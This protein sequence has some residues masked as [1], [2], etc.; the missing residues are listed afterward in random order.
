MA[1]KGKKK[2]SEYQKQK[3]RVKA[4]KKSMEKRGYIFPD[5]SFVERLT[6]AFEKSTSTATRFLKGL[7][8]GKMQEKSI[9]VDVMTGEV[10]SGVA[11]RRKE[12]QKAYKKG[13][14]PTPPTPPGPEPTP[15]TPPGPEP[16]PP[17]PPGP[18]PEP[19][20]PIE[21]EFTDEALRVLENMIVEW[22][23]LGSW[24]D[25]F[26]ILKEQDRNTAYNILMG[27]IDDLGREQVARN[28]QNNAVTL[29]WILDHILYDSGE[30]NVGPGREGQ[31]ANLAHFTTLVRS[32]A[33]TLQQARAIDEAMESDDG[34][35][36]VI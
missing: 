28:C 7:T 33:I 32:G 31:R 36:Y 14:Q 24:S 8:P 20:P 23:P 30:A 3:K 15:P 19:T 13:R 10:I 29:T 2:Q 22:T 34:D 12:R 11:G 9:Y 25:T 35:E 5:V 4:L 18:G 26:K 17:T 1:K 16:T 6:K 27:A 21:P